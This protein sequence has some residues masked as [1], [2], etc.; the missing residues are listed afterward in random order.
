MD[1]RRKDVPSNGSEAKSYR[2][3]PIQ[4][5]PTKE[6]LLVTYMR[7]F[8]IKLEGKLVRGAVREKRSGS[9]A[10]A[11]DIVAAARATRKTGKEEECISKV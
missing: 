8:Q 11:A 1:E 9:V 10:P 4:A 5:L 3:F 6:V 2:I 7:L